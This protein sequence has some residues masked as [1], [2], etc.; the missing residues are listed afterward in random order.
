M[1]LNLLLGLGVVYTFGYF[2]HREKTEV[3]EHKF[4]VQRQ[5]EGMDRHHSDIIFIGDSLI[6]EGH[7]PYWFQDLDIANFGVD[8]S[9]AQDIYYRVHQLFHAQ[10][11]KIF[12]MVG[13]NDLNFSD[14][15]LD[16]DEAKAFYA[17]MLERIHREV[18]GAEVYVHKVLPTTDPWPRSFTVETLTP[19]N[20]FI[21][22]QAQSYG[23]RVI[24]LLPVMANESGAL[25]AAYTDDGLHLNA[26]GYRV[27]IDTLRPL[28]YGARP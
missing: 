1:L 18:P 25:K 28:L 4:R 13:I 20:D 21:V 7:W 2:W 19:L 5:I 17:K 6:A 26:D 14:L 3:K 9:Q 27:W 15:T 12:I 24:D 11:Q 10:P 23:Y 16:F 8:A 22:M